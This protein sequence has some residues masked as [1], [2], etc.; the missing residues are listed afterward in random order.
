MENKQDILKHLNEIHTSLLDSEKFM[1]YD[2][3]AI[4]MWGAISSVLFLFGGYAFENST[5]TGF[6]FLSLFLGGGIF[7]ERKMIAKE[8]VKH[9]LENLTKIQKFFEQTLGAAIVMGILL[10]VLLVEHALVEY[11]YLTWIFLIGFCV[12]VIGFTLNSKPFLNNGKL[13][14][15]VSLVLFSL[16]LLFDFTALNQLAALALL[17]FGHIYLGWKLKQEAKSV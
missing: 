6:L 1:P 5:L 3:N 13:S 8:N 17:G 4:I 7:I 2:Y 16:G 14:I 12:Y 9:E 15:V 11:V 10:S